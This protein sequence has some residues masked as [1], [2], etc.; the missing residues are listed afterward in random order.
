VNNRA[1]LARIEALI[2]DSGFV[3][4]LMSGIGRE[5]QGLKTNAPMIRLLFIGTLL[6]IKEC[7]SA[8]ISGAYTALTTHLDI[9]DQLRL[10]VKTGPRPNDVIP[11]DRLYYAAELVTSRLAYGKSVAEEIGES[12]VARRRDVVL[13]ASNAL[14]NYTSEATDVDDSRLAIDATAI[15][16]W[17]RG[18]YYPKPTVAEIEAQEDPLIRAELQKLRNGSG[19]TDDLVGANLSSD[20]KRLVGLDLD[21]AWSGATAKNGGTKRFYGYYAHLIAAVPNARRSDDP[22]AIA[23]IVRRVELLRATEDVVDVSLRMIDSLPALPE[24]FLGDRHYSYKEYARWASPLLQRGIRQV[25]D[26]RSDDHNAIWLPEGIFVDGFGHCPAMPQEHLGKHRPG[27]FAKQEEHEQFQREMGERERYAHGVINLMDSTGRTKLRCPARQYKVACPLFPPSMAVAAELGLPI[28]NADLLELE[29]GEEPPRCCSQDSFRITLPE[30][31]AKLNQTYYW[32]SEAWYRA[33]RGRTY[34]EGVFG[35]IK[36]PRTENLSRGTIQKTGLVWS[37]LI[38]TLMC[39]TYNVRIIRERH[40]RLELPWTGH[41]LLSPDDDTVTHVSLNTHQEQ[42]LFADFASGISLDELDVRV[43][44]E[45][46]V[47]TEPPCSTPQRRRATDS[48]LPFW[49][50]TSTRGITTSSVSK[51]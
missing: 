5:P 29:P 46:N 34:V 37:Q 8:T 45:G 21:A 26:L 10:G 40:A 41:A 23:P 19:A 22:A 9:R 2:D 12:E 50:N 28:V 36:N 4:T 25:L 47:S 42:E 35:N 48:P 13:R 6:S 27:V 30:P 16:A 39:A 38:V 11:R 24:E 51:Q 7:K 20:P 1:S 15:W 17:A 14:L 3:T 43:A 44:K 33:F 18:P 31:V 49:L 32:G